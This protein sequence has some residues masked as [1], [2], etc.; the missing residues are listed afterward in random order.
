M[1]YAAAFSTGS[2]I[3][4]ELGYALIHDA[5]FSPPPDSGHRISPP[6][7]LALQDLYEIGNLVMVDSAHPPSWHG[8]A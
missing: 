2:S 5:T 7:G 1:I 8:T 3:S 6:V 4:T